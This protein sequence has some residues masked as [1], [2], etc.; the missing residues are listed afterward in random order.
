MTTIVTNLI[1]T[2]ARLF[3]PLLAADLYPPLPE[4]VDELA[5]WRRVVEALEARGVR[6]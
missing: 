6:L 2:V 1:W 3:A 5:P 4:A